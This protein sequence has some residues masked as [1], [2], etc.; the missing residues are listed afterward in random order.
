LG[1]IDAE[2]NI[3][4]QRKLT[5]DFYLQS[6]NIIAN[7]D[8][9]IFATNSTLNSNRARVY[10]LDLLELPDLI[11]QDWLESTI[12][13][14][15]IDLIIDIK[16]LITKKL[17]WDNFKLAAVTNDINSAKED[18]ESFLLG[19]NVPWSFD[20]VIWN[21]TI[22]SRYYSRPGLCKA[23]FQIIKLIN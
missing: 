3:F 23:F 19:N 7:L 22:F 12:R 9:H 15:D 18:C 5:L 21:H 13:Q 14:N 16:K 6:D 17:I 10:N 4:L 2:I 1:D 11:T 20:E 8:L